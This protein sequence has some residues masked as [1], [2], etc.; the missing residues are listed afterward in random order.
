[1]T[2]FLSIPIGVGILLNSEYSI[3][4][5]INIGMTAKVKGNGTKDNPYIIVA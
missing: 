5:V 3:R 4:P 2:V 1:M